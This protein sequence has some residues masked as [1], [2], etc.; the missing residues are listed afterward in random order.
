M[1]IAIEKRLAELTDDERAALMDRQ[2]S[3]EPRLQEQVRGILGRVQNAGDDAL[4]AMALEFDG[5]A[6]EE[7]EVPRDLWDGALNR[8]EPELRADLEEAAENI[9]AFH[10]AQIPEDIQVEVRPGVTLGRKAVPLSSVGVY[11]PGGTG[12]LPQQ[13]AHGCGSGASSRSGR[14]DR[15][16]SPR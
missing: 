16:L 5:V 6:L 9:Q 8:L 3:D 14:R 15:L 4:R 2:P 11:A 7:L 1:R 12:S 13:R 10:R